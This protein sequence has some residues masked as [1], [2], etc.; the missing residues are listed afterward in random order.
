MVHSDTIQ[1]SL[2]ALHYSKV[3]AV[4]GDDSDGSNSIRKLYFLNGN[5]K[6]LSHFASNRAPFRSSKT[7][8]LADGQQVIGLYGV[9]G[10]C[11]W[12]SSL[13]ILVKTPNLF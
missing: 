13:G 4:R 11:A 6:T 9:V 1:V 3:K 8:E 2:S 7:Y 5:G 12:I 10:K